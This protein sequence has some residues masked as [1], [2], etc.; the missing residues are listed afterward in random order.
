MILAYEMRATADTLLAALTD[1]Q[2][3]AATRGFD[4]AARRW[5]EYR[6][7]P[8]PGLSL[9]DLGVTARKAAHRLLATALSPPAYAQAMAVLALEEVLDR[10]EDWRRGRHSED[11]RVVVFGTPGD[12]RWGWR[13]EGH[14]LSVSMTVADDVVSPAPVFLGANPARVDTA[15]RVVLRPLAAEEDLGRELLLAMTP[16]ARRRAVVADEA[17]YD[18][19]SGTAPSTGPI[20]PAGVPRADL[21]PG[22]RA[23][24]DQLVA[25]YLGRLPDELAAAYADTLGAEVHFA[26]EGPPGPGGRHYYRV[27]ADDLLIEYDNTTDDGNHAH[28]VLRRPRGD[29]GGDVLAAHRAGPGHTP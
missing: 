11:Y 27:Q 29:F 7:E 13:F 22:E 6:P 1:E 18:I 28:T 16:T 19:R 17:P 26:W 12:D 10:R 23:L 24:L 8:R 15:G 3:A 4:D 25:L 2:E 21:R 5:I 20:P 14:H 9:A